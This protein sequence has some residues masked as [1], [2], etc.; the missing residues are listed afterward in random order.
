MPVS[1]AALRAIAANAVRHLLEADQHYKAARFPSA[2]ASAVLSIEEAGKLSLL[3]AHGSAPKQKRHAV[4]TVLFVAL[5]KT[6]GSWGWMSEWR[7]IIRGEANLADLRLT[8]QLHQDVATHSEFAKFLG[9]VQ[10]GE[11]SD[12]TERVNESP[13]RRLREKPRRPSL[14]GL[15]FAPPGW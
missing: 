12:S 15:Q 5:L 13:L 9:R 8:A 7:K 4:H 6:L 14:V 1:D 11:L 2:T 3:V 10:A